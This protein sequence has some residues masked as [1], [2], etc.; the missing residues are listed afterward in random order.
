MAKKK[1]N[2]SGKAWVGILIAIAI[3]VVLFIVGVYVY[4]ALTK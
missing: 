1:N 3:I 4:F 2:E